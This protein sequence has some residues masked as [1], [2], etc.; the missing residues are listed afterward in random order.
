MK[1]RKRKKREKEKKEVFLLALPW[2]GAA[3]L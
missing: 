2:Y 1:K 3:A